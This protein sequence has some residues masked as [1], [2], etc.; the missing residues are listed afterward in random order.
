MEDIAENRRARFDYEP[1]EKFE[2]GISL[3]GQE[4]KSARAGHMQLAGSYAVLRDGELW[5][6]NSVIP[7]YQPKNAP[8]DYDQSR[9]R[10]LL[11]HKEEINS[12]AGRIQEK[13][14]SLV[15]FRAYPSHGRIKIEIVLARSR[16][17]GDKRE[18][19]KKRTTLREIRKEI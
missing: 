17:R 7:P 18:L 13:G 6:L 14:L 9:S 2:A 15:P 11:L 5:L 8:E 4:V 3:T 16:K 19:L 10:R 12:L 1:L